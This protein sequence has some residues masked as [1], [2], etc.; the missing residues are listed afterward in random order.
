VSAA[1]SIGLRGDV[2][3][4]TLAAIAPRI[5]AAGFHG[6]W[7]NDNHRGQSLDGLAAVAAVTTRLQLGTG[8]IAL[9][10][11]SADGIL[12]KLGELPVDRL[13]LGVGSGGTSDALARV[14]R[15][16][17]TLRAGTT[18]SVVVGALG[19]RMRRLAADRA[20]GV[21]LN[22][23]TPTAAASAT[24]DLRRDAGGRAVRSILYARTIASP[25]DAAALDTECARYS[26]I[27]TYAANFA[28]LGIEAIDTT[29]RTPADLVA[30]RPT[31]DEIVLRAITTGG[32]V[33]ELERLVDAYAPATSSDSD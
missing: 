23:L 3:H 8:V 25:V 1:V 16:V 7:L 18:A 2:D 32:S 19:P 20:D 4:A 33:V 30:F 12:A 5:E 15:A 24:A 17:G 29:I 21:L 13:T 27:P 9:D 6:L 11:L 14:E 28:R 26:A 22:W 31:V 10:G